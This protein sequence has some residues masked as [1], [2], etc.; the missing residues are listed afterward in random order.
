MSSA[1]AAASAALVQRHVPT[2]AKDSASALAGAPSLS[3]VVGIEEEATKRPWNSNRFS[4]A[5]LLFQVALIILYGTCTTYDVGASNTSTVVDTSGRFAAEYA[6]FQDTHVMCVCG[7]RRSAC[8]GR[9]GGWG[10]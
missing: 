9:G 4:I 5:V 6:M 1:D 7:A 3:A 2:E 8:V 10:G